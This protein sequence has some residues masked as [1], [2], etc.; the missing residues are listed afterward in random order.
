MVRSFSLEWKEALWGKFVMAAPRPRLPVMRQ[1]RI[2]EIV[3][4]KGRLAAVVV[5]GYG[6]ARRIDCGWLVL[7]ESFGPKRGW[8]A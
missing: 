7:P 3:A 8:R 2:V 5:D 1:T 6:G 4:A